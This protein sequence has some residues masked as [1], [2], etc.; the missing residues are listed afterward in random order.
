M[1]IKKKDWH[2]IEETCGVILPRVPFRKMV[3]FL[4][5]FLDFLIFVKTSSDDNRGI[6]GRG[7]KNKKEVPFQK[8]MYITV[9]GYFLF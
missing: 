4:S 6:P 5:E 9:S 2:W 1:N 8:N 3:L 7:L